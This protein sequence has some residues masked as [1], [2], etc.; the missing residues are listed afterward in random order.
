V[1][2]AALGLAGYAHYTAGV[3]ENSLPKI[4]SDEDIETV[5]VISKAGFGGAV[6]WLC[7]ILYMKDRLTLA[8]GLV[9]ETAAA[10]SSMPLLVIFVPVFQVVCYAGFTIPW[11]FFLVYMAAMGDIT[12]QMKSFQA[13]AMEVQYAYKSFSYN[14]DQQNLFWFYLFGY[15]WTSEFIVA[16][17]QIITAMALCCYYFTREKKKIGNCT[18]FKSIYLVLRYHVGTVAFGSFLIAV[19]RLLRAYV[20][21]LERTALKDKTQFQKLL[22]RCLKCFMWCLERCI[23]YINLHAYIQTCIWGTSFCVSAFNGFWLIFRNLARIVAV[24]G[25]TGFL[26]MIGRIAVITL[27]GGS[28]YYCMNLYFEGVV[29]NLVVPTV[30]VCIIAAFIAI[31]FFEVF[32]MGTTVLLQ[33]FVADEEMFKDDAEG[34]FATNSLKAYLVSKKGKRKKKTAPA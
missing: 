3:W 34:C 29:K 33:C 32:G 11:L 18:V 7:F 19:V 5:K 8:I 6:F 30:L 28:F 9:I 20:E 24:T 27:T 23:K 10:L 2:F 31:M 22:M 4:S 26:A 16:L 1:F 21:Y 15:F 14:E 25:V 13:G 12:T 17:G